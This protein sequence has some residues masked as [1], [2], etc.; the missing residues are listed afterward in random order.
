MHKFLTSLAAASLL[1]CVSSAALACD[2]HHDVSASAEQN[3]QAIAMSTY[4]GALTPPAVEEQVTAD[5]AATAACT[6]G[7]KDCLPPSE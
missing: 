5:P 4:S 2:W 3:G 6:E 1:A 7:D